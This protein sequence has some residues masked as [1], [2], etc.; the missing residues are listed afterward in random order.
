MTQLIKFLP[1]TIIALLSTQCKSVKDIESSGVR[2][3]ESQIKR[4]LIGSSYLNKAREVSIYLPTITSEDKNLAVVYATDGQEFVKEYKRELDSL[5]EN[6][7]I[8]K[9]IIVGVHSDERQIE[10]SDFSYRNYEYIKSYADSEDEKLSTLYENHYNFFSKELLLYIQ[11]HYPVSTKPKDR[12][13]YGFSNGAGFGVSL[14]TDNPSIISNYIC[15]SMAGGSY[16]D[17]NWNDDNYP[18]LILSYGNKEPFPLTMQIDAFSNFLKEKKIN[19][20]FYK[21]EG[22]HDRKKWKSEFLKSLKQILN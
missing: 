9:L 15:M 20:T 13:F 8:P 7:L 18:N 12:I 3:Q 19:H 10:G 5:I 2:N 22:G 17:L 21:Y 16:E 4:E 1:I 6:N 14:A 11:S